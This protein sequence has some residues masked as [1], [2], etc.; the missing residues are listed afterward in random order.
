MPLLLF[1]SRHSA[2]HNN[3]YSPLWKVADSCHQTANAGLPSCCLHNIIILFHTNLA[4]MVH[5]ALVHH[6]D[7]VT[8]TGSLK[9]FANPCCDTGMMSLTL[10]KRLTGANGQ[11]HVMTQTLVVR[12]VKTLART[13]DLHQV[14]LLLLAVVLGFFMQ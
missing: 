6:S 14:H 3:G 5:Q 11:S 8:H 12:V 10:A 2:C 7:D 1:P 4:S 9:C 13:M